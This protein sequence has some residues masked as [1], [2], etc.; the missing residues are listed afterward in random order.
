MSS[1]LPQLEQRIYI[2]HTG[3]ETDLIFN[4]GV[5]LPNFASFPLLENDLGCAHLNRSYRDITLIARAAGVGVI[6]GSATWMASRD[7][8]ATVGYGPE[9]LQ[10]INRKAIEILMGVRNEFDETP[11]VLSGN[12][13]PR[14]DA[15][16]PE[17]RM[18][19]TESETY[20]S[21]QIGFLADTEADLVT[22]L[23]L[24]YAEEAIGMVRAASKHDVPIALSFTVETDGRLPTGLSIN[25]AIAQVDDATD[26]Y[27]AYFMI[28]CAHPDHFI[29]DFES[30]PPSTRLRG[31]VVNASRCSH[32]ELNEAE[33]LDDGDPV[34]LGQ[35]LAALHTRFPHISV[36]GGCCGT[37]SRHL[38]EIA[39]RVG[40]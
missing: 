36:L 2:C 16:A 20:H 13:G 18:A 4:H 38:T 9:T 6:V 34:E 26:G 21:E 35:Q 24:A 3:I 33:E 7:R 29:A 39:Q 32:A 15:Y 12:I 31:L 11:V 22:G 17:V 14:S 27:A 8:A 1:A 5:D 25:D 23:T 37:D 30:E 28:N 40:T 10:D 19:V